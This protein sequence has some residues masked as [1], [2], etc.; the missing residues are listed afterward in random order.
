M[1]ELSSKP[2]NNCAKA[3]TLAEV[4]ITLAIIGVVAALTIPSVVRN[5]RDTQYKTQ[6]KKA[7]AAM[8]V[9]LQKTVVDMGGVPLCYDS[10]TTADECP[11]F[12]SEFAK[13]LKHI[14]YCDNNA[15]VNGCVPQYKKYYVGDSCV[16]LNQD[17]INNR[18][19][20][21]ILADGSILI[22]YNHGNSPLF[23]YDINGMKG[24]NLPGHDLFPFYVRYERNKGLYLGVAP[25]SQGYAACRQFSAEN[26]RSTEDMMKWSYK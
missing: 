16:G 22:G 14:K 24:P 13:N 10:T 2:L 19:N 3:F 4:L 8:S 23:G 7:Y 5:Y 11:K 1:E 20:V 25:S 26:G 21:W 15:L 12:F 18:N 6:F 17:Y 9:A